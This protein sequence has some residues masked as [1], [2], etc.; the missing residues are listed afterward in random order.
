MLIKS[1]GD[2]CEDTM[3]Q[4]ENCEKELLRVICVKKML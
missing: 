2:D 3:K 4:I 1:C